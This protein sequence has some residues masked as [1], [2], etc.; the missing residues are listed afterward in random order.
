MSIYYHPHIREFLDAI[1]PSTA[2][3][4]DISEQPLAVQ[5]ALPPPKVSK[6]SSQAGDQNQGAKGDKDKDKGKEKLLSLEAKSA[7]EDAAVKTKEAEA[8][9]KKVGPKAKDAPTSQ[10][11]QKE[12]PPTPK[13]KTQHF[14]FILFQQ[15]FFFCFFVFFFFLQ[16]Y[17]V[18]GCNVLL[19]I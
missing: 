18:A 11:S 7:D 2:I 1:P 17:S 13:S 10:P 9:T 14:G 12:D 4:P 19:F 16:W 15:Q 5:F 3:A 6:G 8:Q